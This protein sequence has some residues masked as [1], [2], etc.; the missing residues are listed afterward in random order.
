RE[1]WTLPQRPAPV[2]Q[3]LRQ[4]L[5]PDESPRRPRQLLNARSVAQGA[6]RSQASFFQRRVAHRLLFRLQFEMRLQLPS[7]FLLTLFPTIRHRRL[8]LVEILPKIEPL[9]VDDLPST[10]LAPNW[11]LLPPSQ[12]G[13]IRPH[14]GIG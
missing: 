4:L 10:R 13:A 5:Q 2:L 6:A 9:R 11:R 14:T 3:I 7:Q 8:P 1:S 12:D